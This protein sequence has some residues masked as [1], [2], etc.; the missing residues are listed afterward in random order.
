MSLIQGRLRFNESKWFAFSIWIQLET[1]CMNSISHRTGR[2]GM[3]EMSLIQGRFRFKEK[4]IY[5]LFPFEFNLKLTAWTAF[6]TVKEW[7]KYPELK[8]KQ[9][10]FLDFFPIEFHIKHSF[11]T[12]AIGKV[13]QEWWGKC[14]EVEVDWDEMGWK[15]SSGNKISEQSTLPKSK[16]PWMSTPDLNWDPWMAKS[17]GQDSKLQLS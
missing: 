2:A 13:L 7:G 8:W 15:S 6:A 14:P 17:W 1:H 9:R 16:W 4:E 12:S 3:G 5:W 11:N 10:K